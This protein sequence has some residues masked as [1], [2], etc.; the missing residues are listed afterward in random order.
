[1]DRRR[2]M[3]CAVSA[4]AGTGTSQPT[5][6]CFGR[7]YLVEI[8]CLSCAVE[9]RPDCGLV[10]L[11][12]FIEERSWGRIEVRRMVP[13]DG[14]RDRLR[15]LGL[16]L[17]PCGHPIYWSLGGRV[18]GYLG[19]DELAGLLAGVLAGCDR[20]QLYMDPRQDG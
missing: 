20:R 16:N 14:L 15:R 4:A 18:G 7:S 10:T 6:T 8:G 2:F 1:M 13:S 12:V 3:L 19:P 11:D 5:V 17:D 9:Q